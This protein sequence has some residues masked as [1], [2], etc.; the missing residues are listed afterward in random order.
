ARAAPGGRA[1][2]GVPREDP[3]ADPHAAEPDPDPDRVLAAPLTLDGKV[4]IVTGGARGIG[5]AVADGLTRAGATVAIADLDPPEGGIRADVS[6]EGDCERM[7]REAVERH[8]RIDILVNNAGLYAT[9]AMRPFTEIPLDEWR[10]V[11]DVNVA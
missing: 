10:R 1:L 2:A 3:A 7:A 9:L 5:R 4:A 8:G 11:M 6:D